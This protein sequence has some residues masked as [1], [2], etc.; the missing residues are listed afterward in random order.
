M[1][2]GG[3]SIYLLAL[4]KEGNLI[5][6]HTYGGR[7]HDAGHGIARMSDGSL[8]VAGESNSFERSKNFYMLKIEK[9]PNN[10]VKAKQ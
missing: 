6:S 5:W 9:Q 2:K 1:G 7:N 3:H 8:V 10:A 4:D